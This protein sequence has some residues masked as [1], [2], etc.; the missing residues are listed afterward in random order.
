MKEYNNLTLDAERALYGLDGANVKNCRFSGPADG[1]SA[2][3]ECKNINVSG[4]FFNLRYPLW[5]VKNCELENSEMTENCR[6]ALWYDEDIK[7]KEC[8]L[9]GIKALRECNNTA[10]NKC[11]LN[12][13]EVFWRC[14]NIVLEACKLTSEYP[15]FE[16]RD[17]DISELE[18]KGKY[19]FQYVENA[20]LKNCKLNTKDAFWHSKNITVY[21]SEINGEYLGWY[22][23]NLTLIR[24]RISGTQPLCYCK[25][26]S[27][28][29]CTMENTDLS[30]ERSEVYAVIKGS[31]LS[32]KNPLCGKIEADSIGELI[33]EEEYIDPS[34]T[35][36]KIGDKK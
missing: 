12:S 24:C 18:M 35:N 9:N 13:P 10:L 15:F 21:D 27:L 33:M 3:K 28:K 16:C 25:N 1:E 14:K 20:T 2:L 17:L 31:I 36:I 5:H 4:C 11:T 23:E 19:S 30:F 29:D 6:A 26:L 7:I 32:V 8:T 34:K 22:S